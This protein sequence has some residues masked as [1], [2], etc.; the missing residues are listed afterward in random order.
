MYIEKKYIYNSYIYTINRL[1]ELIILEYKHF[2][3][4]ISILIKIFF[5][6]CF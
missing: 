4:F 3:I 1:H 2:Q 6:F 5:L